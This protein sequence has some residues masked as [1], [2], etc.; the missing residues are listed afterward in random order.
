MKLSFKSECK[1]L[2]QVNTKWKKKNVARKP[3]IAGK[4]ES[5]PDRK[6]IIYLTK[7]DPYKRGRSLEEE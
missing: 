5:S 3:A 7:L 2:S 6:E 4:V 1:I